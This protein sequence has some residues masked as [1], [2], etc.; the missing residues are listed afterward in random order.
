MS[1]LLC[2]PQADLQSVAKET[3]SKLQVTASRRSVL[4]ADAQRQAAELAA[5][6]QAM[7]EKVRVDRGGLIDCDKSSCSLSAWVPACWT[8]E[9]SIRARASEEAASLRSRLAGRGDA[10]QTQQP[11]P[12]PPEASKST[13]GGAMMALAHSHA[14]RSAELTLQQRMLSSQRAGTQVALRNAVWRCHRR[15]V[16]NER[17]LPVCM[18]L[19][20]RCRRLT[21]MRLAV[22]LRVYRHPLRYRRLYV[23][24]DNSVLCSSIC[25][26]A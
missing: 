10:S 11:P 13:G 3:S 12:P 5:A 24:V 20:L 25:D 9:R 14:L 26:A 16:G 17:A 2:M 15:D 7:V 1:P 21:V 19:A 4:Q 6:E 18:P 22:L 23:T 8:Q